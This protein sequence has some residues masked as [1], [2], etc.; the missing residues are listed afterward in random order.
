M[1]K[2]TLSVAALAIAMSSFGCDACKTRALNKCVPIHVEFDK[3]K[4]THF[5]IKHSTS[6]FDINTETKDQSVAD[7]LIKDKTKQRF[8]LREIIIGAE[9]M[10]EYIKWDVENGKIYQEY[11]DLYI[12]NLL[13]IISKAEDVVTKL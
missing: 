7:Y 2:I 8:E 6:N 12:E 11:A 13:K 4:T 9:D 3:I 10:I 5:S 1:K